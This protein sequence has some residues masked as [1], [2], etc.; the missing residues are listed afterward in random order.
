MPHIEAIY[1]L[2]V[3]QPLEPV[4][5]PEEERVQLSFTPANGQTPQAWLNQVKA[6]QTAIAR[7]H[8]VLPDSA[9]EIASDRRR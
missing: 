3:F 5:L 2:G 6:L 9:S 7:R 1:R 8:G 4:C